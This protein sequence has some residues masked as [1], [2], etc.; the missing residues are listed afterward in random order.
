MKYY[1]LQNN[2]AH[3]PYLV[4]TKPHAFFMVMGEKYM[5]CH[6][7]WVSPLAWPDNVPYRI[8]KNWFCYHIETGTRCGN[9]SHWFDTKKQAIKW[10]R[11]MI[12]NHAQILK[13][14]FA[15]FRKIRKKAKLPS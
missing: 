2:P 9:D 1:L 10:S 12:K 11:M 13:K 6:P 7:A 8:G 4:E 15:K 5:V 14:Q 3:G